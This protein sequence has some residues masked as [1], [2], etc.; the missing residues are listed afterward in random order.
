MTT[1]I[2][3]LCVMVPDVPVTTTLY[4]PA[5]AFRFAGGGVGVTPCEEPPPQPAM[6]VPIARNTKHTASPRNC[7]RPSSGSIRTN[8]KANT[9]L[10]AK[11]PRCV[12]VRSSFAEVPV[13]GMKA[14]MVKDEVAAP[15]TTC[16]EGLTVHPKFVAD[17]MQPS[18]MVA[19][20]PF[21]PP[22]RGIDALCPDLTTTRAALA[23]NVKSVNETVKGTGAL[24][25]GSDPTIPRYTAVTCSAPDGS[26][27][28]GTVTVPVETVVLV[29]VEGKTTTPAKLLPFANNCTNPIGARLCDWLALTL[30]L[31]FT[32]PELSTL[33][34]LTDKVV[35]VAEAVAFANVYGAGDV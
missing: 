12:P 7:S 34:G 19:L 20:P 22:S 27:V 28:A 13:V 15:W 14:L 6:N 31:N 8:P 30:T 32:E 35:V 21:G 16:V 25:E 2:F 24:L 23:D 33:D 1:V 17:G 10:A 3:E 18:D 29:A 5:G 11:N 9:A 26:S 4:V